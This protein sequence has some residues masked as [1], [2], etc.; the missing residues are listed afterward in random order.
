[1]SQ[2]SVTLFAMILVREPNESVHTDTQRQVAA[3]RRVLRGGSTASSL[4]HQSNP[5]TSFGQ[6]PLLQQNLVAGITKQ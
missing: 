6:T 3:S 5:T 2:N 4:D 1:M